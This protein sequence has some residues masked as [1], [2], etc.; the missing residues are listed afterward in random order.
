MIHP[1]C[2][3]SAA[4]A[5]FLGV[6]LAT[7]LASSP[8]WAQE[9]G[10][11][12]EAETE[13]PAPET[14]PPDT[15]SAVSPA[16]T[17]PPLAT[18]P[19]A[20]KPRRW[21]FGGGIGASFGD[22][23]YIEV[24]PFVGYRINPKT[25]TGVGFL[26]RYRNDDRYGREISTSDYGFNLFGRYKIYQ[27]LFVHGE[28]ELLSYEFL[29]TNGFEDRELFSSFFAGGGISQPLGKS[30]ESPA[31][32]MLALY[33][34]SHDGDDFPQPYDTPWSVRVGVSMGF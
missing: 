11:T 19:L 15:A 31:F 14:A 25:A 4:R 28:Y 21:F 30:P 20:P 17:T 12:P 27:P 1:Q 7:A 13:A 22:V 2:C 32:F 3:R 18:I 24:T 6:V 26:Y 9:A 29:T 33:N 5:G 8:I 16:S 10:D 23:D 34:F